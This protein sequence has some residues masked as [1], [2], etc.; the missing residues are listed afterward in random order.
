M[1]SRKN[2][3]QAAIRAAVVV[4]V[5]IG[6]YFFI[7]SRKAEK[8][9]DPPEKVSIAFS[10]PHVLIAV[11][12]TKGY[13]AEEGLEMTPLLRSHGKAALQE[14]LDGKADFAGTAETPA[15][16]AIMKGERISILAT[17]QTSS[18]NNAIVARRDRGII[19]P[20]DL[21]GRTI[22]TTRGTTAHFFIDAFLAARGIANKDIK[23]VELKPEEMPD[24][25]ARGEVDAVATFGYG[26]VKAR[27]KLG[28]RGI[29]FYD[30]DIYTQ[31]L[32][33]VAKQE[34]ISRNPGT[35]RKILRG[36]LKAE[37]F[38][39]QN[40]A[41]ARQLVADLNRVD[42]KL[43]SQTLSESRFGVTLDQ[44]LLLSMEDEA[45]WAIKKG[46]IRNATGEPNYL[47]YIY[48][49]GLE[50]VKPEAVRILR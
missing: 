25:L 43:V 20:L 14:L 37:E 12:Q 30:E 11:A 22:A 29:T 17:V 36:L 18:R 27:T 33:V 46:V 41:E 50:S 13:F 38:A 3:L 10:M 21:K 32:I 26:L 4:A 1:I 34:Y 9:A 44:S 15:M 45:Q 39:V 24:A 19:E 35:V 23:L 48:F 47:D 28:D 40:P 7:S 42:I 6:G 2:K 16:F 31:S 5:V 49:Q 8:P